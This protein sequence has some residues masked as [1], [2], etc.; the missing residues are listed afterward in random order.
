MCSNYMFFKILTR[1]IAYTW[2]E[3]KL[4]MMSNMYSMLKYY[5]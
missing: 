1:K 5:W 2:S 4:I 3:Y